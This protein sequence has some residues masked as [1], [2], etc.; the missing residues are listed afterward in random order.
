MKHFYLV[1]VMAALV[2]VGVGCMQQEE[3]VVNPLEGIPGKQM[4]EVTSENWE[5]FDPGLAKEL[6][7][8]TFDYTQLNEEATTNTVLYQNT[9]YGFEVGLPYNPEWRIKNLV[10]VPYEAG[11]TSVTFGPFTVFGE[12]TSMLT[13]PGTLFVTP[14]RTVSEI[15]KERIAWAKEM[16]LEEPDFEKLNIGNLTVYRYAVEMLNGSSEYETIGPNNNIVVKGVSEEG[17]QTIFGSLKFF[18]PSKRIVVTNEFARNNSEKLCEEKFNT[19]PANTTV[20]YRDEMAGFE[21]KV[22]YNEKWGN[23]KYSVA[24]HEQYKNAG[25]R[26]EG[27]IFGPVHTRWEEGGCGGARKIHLS[28]VPV[29]SAAEIVQS[30]VGEPKP[31]LMNINGLTVAKINDFGMCTDWAYEV[32]G[33]KH[34][35]RLDASCGSDEEYIMIEQLLKTFTLIN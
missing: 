9:H 35:Y 22:P 32:A 27:F 6:E 16:G 15:E 30:N 2:F 31:V 33:K 23:D 14:K 26:G 4:V 21:V 3:T 7:L 29:K 12:G 24:P 10:P 19:D 18:E 1:P 8:N 34:N 13:R 11:A 28:V 5:Q 17:M 25:I 20:V